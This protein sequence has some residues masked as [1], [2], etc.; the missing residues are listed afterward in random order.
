MKFVA[1][2]SGVSQLGPIKVICEYQANSENKWQIAVFI[3]EPTQT[4]FCILDELSDKQAHILANA[5]EQV[6]A[7]AAMWAVENS[8]VEDSRSEL[9]DILKKR[10]NR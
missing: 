2:S 1:G 8:A 5:F 7:R 6:A 4:P 10:L 3:S 9:A